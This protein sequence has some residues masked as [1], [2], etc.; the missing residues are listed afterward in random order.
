MVFTFCKKH[1]FDQKWKRLVLAAV[2]LISTFFFVIPSH[3]DVPAILK[4]VEV[5]TVRPQRIE[6]TVRLIGT[7]RAKHSTLLISKMTGVLEILK[8]SG[9]SV[10][11]G[12]LIARIINPDIEKRYEF[13]SSTAQIAKEQYERTLKLL[14]TGASSKQASEE[15]QAALLEA[16]RNLAATKIELD[17]IRFYAPFDGI[18]GVY[19]EREGTE[20]KSDVPLLSFYDP[21]ALIVDFDIPAPLLRFVN[22]GQKVV[23]GGKNYTLKHVQKMLDPLTHMA[24]AV[25]DIAGKE[26]VIGMSID[27]DL[28]VS[29]KENAFVLP[30][31]AVFLDQGKPH[32]YVVKDLTATLVPVELGIRSK[33]KVEIL[34]GVKK[35]DVIVSQGQGRLAN[36]MKIRIY[37]AEK[38]RKSNSK[39]QVAREKLN[40]LNRIFR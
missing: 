27:V 30:D 17:K 26:H 11:K 35:G 22:V 8:Q 3:K 5:V 28:T 6:Q 40:E 14:K 10:T 33:D 19:K 32:I 34:K 21:A 1:L 15:K 38:D 12:T 31:E 29:E 23:V 37:D 25:V 24:P 39:K 36:G 9:E 18:I 7:V 4:V 2:L 13:A 16:E 20:I